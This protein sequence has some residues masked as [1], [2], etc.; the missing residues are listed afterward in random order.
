MKYSQM[1]RST[2]GLESA[3]EWQELKNMLPSFKGKRWMW[4]W[5]A[6]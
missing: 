6:L 1:E 5:M 4:I 3:G 2:Y